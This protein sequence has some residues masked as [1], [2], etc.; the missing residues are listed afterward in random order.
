MDTVGFMKQQTEDFT[1]AT[2]VKVQLINMSWD[3]VAAK[4][5]TAMAA[6]SSSY[7]VIEFDNSWVTKFTTNNWVIPLDSY[8]TSDMKTGI[9]PGL[10]Q[11]F[12]GTM[13]LGSSCITKPN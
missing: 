1:K 12:H 2:G 9:N 10:L 4:V 3:D 11:T 5:T 13:I 8:M 6:G 7:D